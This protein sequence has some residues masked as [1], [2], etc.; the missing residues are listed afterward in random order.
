MRLVMLG[1]LQS[2]GLGWL[3]RRDN[4]WVNVLQVFL[5]AWRNV[6]G[7][8]VL[9]AVESESDVLLVHQLVE[10]IL[11]LLVDRRPGRGA[12]LWHWNLSGDT[13]VLV[14][15]VKTAVIKLDASFFRHVAVPSVRAPL[16]LSSELVC[17]LLESMV[18]WVGSVNGGR[19]EVLVERRLDTKLLL[20]SL[21]LVPGLPVVHHL[22]VEPGVR[23]RCPLLNVSFSV[24]V[25]ASLVSGRDIGVRSERGGL[26]LDR[27]MEVDILQLEINQ[28]VVADGVDAIVQLNV[29]LERLVSKVDVLQHTFNRDVGVGQTFELG[30]DG[31]D[32]QVEEAVHELVLKLAVA[33]EQSQILAVA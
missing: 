24:V 31:V 11:A 5:L 33:K 14:L 12:G 20:V 9:G 23:L 18:L 27:V 28:V 32:N 30:A 19:V 6:L 3:L 21:E 25:A 8:L 13:G 29:D 4:R 2:G 10:K 7:W 16:D 17:L 22:E 15:F 26:L 1:G